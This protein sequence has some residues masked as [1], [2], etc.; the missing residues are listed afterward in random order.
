MAFIII[1][2]M[3]AKAPVWLKNILVVRFHTVGLQA[4]TSVSFDHLL[5]KINRPP[6]LVFK[7]QPTAGYGQVN[8]RMP[9]KL[10]TVSMQRHKQS[11]FNPELFGPHSAMS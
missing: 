6:D 3:A 4:P 9:V 8:M 10:A 5:F 11:R 1:F 7:A 2:V